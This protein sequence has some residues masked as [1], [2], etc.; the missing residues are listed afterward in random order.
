M[1]IYEQEGQWFIGLRRSDGTYG[2]NGPHNA[3]PEVL[4]GHADERFEYVDL[5]I[6]EASA[7]IVADAS[8]NEHLL[9]EL[10]QILQIQPEVPI[11]PLLPPLLAIPVIAGSAPGED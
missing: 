1:Q 4:G 10:L 8:G 5:K 3:K 9:I 6:G 11:N 7:Q 2:P